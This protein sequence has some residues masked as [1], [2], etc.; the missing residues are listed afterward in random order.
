VTAHSPVSSEAANDDVRTGFERAVAPLLDDLHRQARG[1]TR[2]AADAEDLV[3][4]TMLKAYGAFGS[5]GPDSHLKAWLFRIMRNLWIDDYRRSLR[6]PDEWLTADV[7]E[8]AR[9]SPLHQHGAGRDFVEARFVVSAQCAC[10]REAMREL[11]EAL[12]RALYFAYIEGF[13]YQEIADLEGVPVGTVMSRLYR[14]RRVL[15]RLLIE[16]MAEA[17]LAEF[18]EAG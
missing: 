13:R 15:R 5:W 9:D 8:R 14:A 17:D 11:P 10:V 18:A 1:L 2:N 4:D 16:R 7:T 3:Q 12:R 6:R